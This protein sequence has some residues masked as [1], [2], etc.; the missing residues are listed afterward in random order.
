MKQ[1]NFRFQMLL[2]FSASSLLMGVAICVLIRFLDTNVVTLAVVCFLAFSGAVL[3]NMF[4]A[5]KI[6]RPMEETMTLVEKMKSSLKDQEKIRKRLCSDVAHELRTPLANVSSYLEAMTEEIWEATPERLEECYQELG[7]LTG[8]V[9]DLEELHRVED[10]KLRL[11]KETFDLKEL[12]KTVVGTFETKLR[13]KKLTC[14]IL[15]E[16]VLVDA[17]RRRIHQVIFNLISNAIKY[18]EEGDYIRVVAENNEDKVL[19]KVQDHGIGVPESERELVFERF[20]R[21]DVSR[22]RKTGGAGIGLSIAKAIMDAHGGLIYIEDTKEK[23]TCFVIS[24]PSLS[25]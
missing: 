17:D 14:E 3:L 21:T 22:C 9:A 6:A 25:E 4:L 8:I 12:A 10:D 20:Y 24:L 13:E 1:N 7:R 18:T 23:G 15:G 16:S 5:K 2:G 19:L 11:E